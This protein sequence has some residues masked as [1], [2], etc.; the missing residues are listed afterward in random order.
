MTAVTLLAIAVRTRTSL[1][2]L[3]ADLA[4]YPQVLLNVRVTRQV[5]RRSSGGARRDRRSRAR[6]R[7]RR[8]HTRAAVGDRAAG[9][10]DGRGPRRRPHQRRG[11]VGRRRDPDRGRSVRSAQLPAGPQEF[12]CISRS[13]RIGVAPGG[14]A[15]PERLSRAPWPRVGVTGPVKRLAASLGF[16]LHLL[17]DHGVRCSRRRSG[18]PSR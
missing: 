16:V 8:T 2:E 15:G 14:D 3:A 13:L 1:H 18:G 4:V 9:T 6:A 5:G 17:T 7:A 11:R 10:G 12:G